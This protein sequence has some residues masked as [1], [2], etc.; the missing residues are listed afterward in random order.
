MRAMAEVALRIPR[1]RVGIDMMLLQDT[2]L[3][4]EKGADPGQGDPR[5]KTFEDAPGHGA[6][7]Q[8]PGRSG[9]PWAKAQTLLDQFTGWSGMS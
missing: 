6:G 2:S 3:R 7:R 9:T 5:G 8:G 1:M 4:D